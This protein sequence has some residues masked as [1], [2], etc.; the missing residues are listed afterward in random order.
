MIEPLLVVALPPTGMQPMRGRCYVDAHDG[1][2]HVPVSLEDA[3]RW[4]GMGRV[5]IT[6]TVRVVD[7]SGGGE[8]S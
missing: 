5:E 1:W 3:E 4:A 6:I 2:I 7:G 8:A